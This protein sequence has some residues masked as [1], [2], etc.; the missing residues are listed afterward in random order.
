MQARVLRS[1]VSRPLLQVRPVSAARRLIVRRST[2]AL[3][4]VVAGDVAAQWRT[5]ALAII[6]A[7]RSA[8]WDHIA[9]TRRSHVLAALCQKPLLLTAA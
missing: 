9:P 6:H 4:G 7:E 3:G 2:G 5:P 1:A 8:G